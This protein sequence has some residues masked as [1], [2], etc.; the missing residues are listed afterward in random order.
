[1][2]KSDAST[3][4]RFVPNNTTTGDRK[5][6]FRAWDQSTGVAGTKVDVSVNG[7]TTPSASGRI[8]SP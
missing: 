1:M 3:Y 2:L 8:A 6:F 4:L 7:G 5:I